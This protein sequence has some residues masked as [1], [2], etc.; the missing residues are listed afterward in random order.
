MSFYLAIVSPLDSPLFE[1]S[2]PSP[3]RLNPSQT[4]TSGHSSIPVASSSAAGFPTWSSFTGAGGEGSTTGG[5]AGPA[6]G[7]GMADRALMQMIAFKSLDGV[8]EVQE[9]TGSLYLRNVDKHNEWTVSAYLAMGVK[10]ILV[11][12]QKNDDGI[13][14]FF[15]ELWELWVKILLNPF[16]TVN[17]P[18]RSSAFENRVRGAAK[19]Y[20]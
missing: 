16:H 10:F 6:G 3:S 2:L 7:A 17:T 8:E 9:S 14:M 15:N 20:L 18:V 12:D 1:L 19:R 13:R 11:H 5:A 4:P